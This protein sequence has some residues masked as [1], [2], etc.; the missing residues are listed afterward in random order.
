MRAFLISFLIAAV[1][2][3][4][5]AQTNT[6]TFSPMFK[7]G[8]LFACSIIFDNYLPDTAYL[9]A[10]PVHAAGSWSVNFWPDNGIW[11]VL[12]LGITPLDSNE[13]TAPSD[14]YIIIGYASNKADQKFAIDSDAPGFKLFGFDATAENT[15]Q[16]IL[17]PIEQ[18]RF[19]VGY[20]LE[21]GSVATT[22]EVAL[23]D[24]QAER[25][26]ECLGTLTQSGRA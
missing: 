21:G 25:Y 23:S 7:D 3:S 18:G 2:P 11:G 26:S 6:A 5:S 14:G 9:N 20:T 8:A 10:T 19:T 16:A 12:K 13:P 24:D 1:A 22:F 15:L 4:A 17:A